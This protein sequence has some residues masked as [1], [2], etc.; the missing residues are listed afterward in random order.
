MKYFIV[1]LLTR[2]VIINRPLN[3]LLEVSVK[4]FNDQCCSFRLTR[5][6]RRTYTT[7]SLNRYFSGLFVDYLLRFRL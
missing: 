4:K 7:K 5:M 2:A 1:L 3:C 6:Q